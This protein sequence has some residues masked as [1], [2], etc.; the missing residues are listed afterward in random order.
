MYYWNGEAWSGFDIV[1]GVIVF[2]I[3]ALTILAAIRMLSG[4]HYLRWRIHR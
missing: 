1:F 3:W 4:G 2:T